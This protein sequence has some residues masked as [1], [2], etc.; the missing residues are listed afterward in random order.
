MR[1]DTVFRFDSSFD[2][3]IGVYDGTNYTYTFNESRKCFMIPVSGGTINLLTREPMNVGDQVSNVKD[4]DGTEVFSVNG[5]PYPMF[6]VAAAPVM[7]P[8]GSIIGWNH[9]IKRQIPK[10]LDNA[11]TSITERIAG[12]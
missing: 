11:I 2:H 1:A 4:R 5:Q 12:L 3:F 7:S 10:N 9:Q 8:F 6:V